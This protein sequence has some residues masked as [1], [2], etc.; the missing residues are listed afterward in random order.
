MLF[1]G[2]SFFSHL[3]RSFEIKEYNIIENTCAMQ[4]SGSWPPPPV[5]RV[6]HSHTF[7]QLFTSGWGSLIPLYVSVFTFQISV[8]PLPEALAVVQTFIFNCVPIID[9][10][11]QS[12][13]A[14]I[15]I[16]HLFLKDRIQPLV[17]EFQVGSIYSLEMQRCHPSPSDFHH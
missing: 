15:F 7:I 6:S 10:F 16:P 3:I 8:F 13:S 17:L 12:L 1:A 14:D 4:F 9:N 5:S 11:L 2:F